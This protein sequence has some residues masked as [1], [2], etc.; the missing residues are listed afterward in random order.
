MLCREAFRDRIE[1]LAEAH[2]AG[3]LLREKDLS[4][5]EYLAIGREV[6]AICGQYGVPCILHSFL[7]AAK[8]LNASALHLPLPLLR[9]LAP[10]EKIL[11]R[12][13]GTSC[14][15]VEEA[16]EAEHLGCT[17]LI[18]GHIF[19]TDCKKGLPGRG[20]GFLN[21]VCNCVSI[22]VYAIGG[23]EPNRM[24]AVK[25]AGAA[26]ACIMRRAMSCENPTEYLSRFESEER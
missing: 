11:F 19:E 26:G 7:R 10:E 12:T 8:L 21:E 17:Y 14:H 6:L 23:I 2:P 9:T 24:R 13:L 20:V 5:T 3:I 1:A 15:S 18:A 25:Q 22:P 4:E 16:K